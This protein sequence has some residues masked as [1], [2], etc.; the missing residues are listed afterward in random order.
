MKYLI[1]CI[2]LVTIGEATIFTALDIQKFGLSVEVKC[3]NGV[4]IDVVTGR[5]GRKNIKVEQSHCANY[6][7]WN[8]RNCTHEPIKCD[9][10]R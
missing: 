5:I 8:N 10:E 6:S 2:L 4:L 9:K 3:K 7:A 1:S